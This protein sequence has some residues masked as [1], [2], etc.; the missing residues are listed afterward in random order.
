MLSKLGPWLRTGPVELKA[1]GRVCE[2]VPH[3]IGSW[4]VLALNRPR[5]KGAA[6]EPQRPDPLVDELRGTRRR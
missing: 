4:A 2:P 3:A 5:A 6:P 1:G